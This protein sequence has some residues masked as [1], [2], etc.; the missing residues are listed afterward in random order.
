MTRIEF[1]NKYNDMVSYLVYDHNRHFKEWRSL[2]GLFSCRFNSLLPV[3]QRIM[4]PGNISI[5]NPWFGSIYSKE[6][7]QNRFMAL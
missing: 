3:F 2:C 6:N 7:Q 4:K 5:H 1:I